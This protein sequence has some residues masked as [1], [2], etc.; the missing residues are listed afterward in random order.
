MIYGFTGHRP[1][2]LGG[3]GRVPQQKLYDFAYQALEQNL[4]PGDEAI[5]GMAQGWDM[6]VASACVV[7]TVP[8][9]AAVPYAGQQAV[10]P[11]LETRQHYETLLSNAKD[12]VYIGQPPRNMGE[13]ATL[14]QQRNRYIVEHSQKMIALWDG[15]RGGT[16]NC[17]KYAKYK[18]MPVEYVWKDWETFNA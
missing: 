16:Y 10:W 8:F 5:V 7:L 11:D 1:P 4:H 6:A 18:N 14:L 2:K 15:S 9:T 13:A 3:Y 12:V 17:I